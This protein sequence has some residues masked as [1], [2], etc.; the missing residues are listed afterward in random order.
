MP[1][2]N[3]T[4]KLMDKKITI[5]GI[6]NKGNPNTQIYRDIFRFITLKS[7]E[8]FENKSDPRKYFS[9]SEFRVRELINWLLE[10]NREMRKEF[11][12]AKQSMSYKAHSKTP[13]VTTRLEVLDELDLIKVAKKAPSLRNKSETEVYE[14]SHYGVLIAL[15]L[16]FEGL[17]K[18]TSEY[19]TA[20]SSLFELWITYIPPGN[21]DYN[22]I[23]YHFLVKLLK[24]CIGKYDDL[25]LC[26]LKFIRERTPNLV[27]NFSDLRY[28]TNNVIYKML[29]NNKDFRKLYYDELKGC[30]LDDNY[31]KDCQQ[32]I[33]FQFKLDIEAEIERNS[34]R[35]LNFPSHDIKRFQRNGKQ[36][37]QRLSYGE[38]M[39]NN[40]DEDILKEIVFSY[41]TK[42]EWER[43]RNENL[44]N[45]NIITLI[46]KCERC[47][48]IYPYSFEL[49][50][51]AMDKL[52]CNNCN[53]PKLKLYDFD[54]DSNS[55]Y[56]QD[57]L[58][59]YP[60]I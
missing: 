47:N 27:F 48:Q 7:K 53:Q 39:E 34:S 54:N 22:N 3:N 36:R 42:N 24:K 59:K 60:A 55:L 19:R 38:A 12:G 16:D 26:F 31:P 57:M 10:N 13:Y 5:P 33:R 46:I 11:W 20:L 8:N 49:E 40:Y 21:K 35:V 32:L 50:T 52:E 6:L 1:K 18:G 28:K 9:N 23:N 29:I 51:E 17:I 25:L 37:N 41:W 4:N 15:M 30:E 56:L 43:K 58:S 45:C 44:L 14:L 2:E